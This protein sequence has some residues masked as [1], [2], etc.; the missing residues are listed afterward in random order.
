M[1]MNVYLVEWFATE[2]LRELRAAVG[3]QQLAESLGR[4]PSLRTTLGSALINLGH[5][6]QG[7]RAAATATAAF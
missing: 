6:L 3:R 5:R 2:H 4:K 1:D 7:E